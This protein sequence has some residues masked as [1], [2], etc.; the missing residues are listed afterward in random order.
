MDLKLSWYDTND[1]WAA[2]F[3]SE[4]DLQINV[5]TRLVGIYDSDENPIWEERIEGEPDWRELAARAEFEL[6]Y[7]LRLVADTLDSSPLEAPLPELE[8]TSEALVNHIAD[9]MKA[10]EPDPIP[11]PALPTFTLTKPANEPPSDLYWVER[12]ELPSLFY[13]RTNHLPAESGYSQI[14]TMIKT[15]ATTIKL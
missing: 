7:R 6:A 1:G 5:H 10:L 12:K 3:S 9:H 2:D 15:E 13:F 8:A 11:A 14:T 4:L